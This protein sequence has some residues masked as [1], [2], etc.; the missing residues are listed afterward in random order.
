MERL[1]RIV[2]GDWGYVT[3]Y[4]LVYGVHVARSLRLDLPYMSRTGGLPLWVPGDRGEGN[5]ARAD[6]TFFETGAY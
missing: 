2:G 4:K 3:L 5:G 1:S 6:L